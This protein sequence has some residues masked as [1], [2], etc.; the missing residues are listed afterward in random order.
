ML[1]FWLYHHGHHVVS[2]VGGATAKV[3]DP[4]GRL[5]ARAKTAESTIEGNLERM[6]TQLGS[7]WE[8]VLRYGKRHGQEQGNV[9]TKEV[10]NNATWLEGL[11]VLMFLRM[12]GNG[13]RLGT[14]LGR[15]T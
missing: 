13:A 5:T 1:L 9:G 14:M 11:K 10:L 8:N 12:M 7:L 4:S 2:L 6:H 3:G 15:D